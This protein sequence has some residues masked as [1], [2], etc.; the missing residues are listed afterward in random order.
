MKL[1]DKI[2]TWIGLGI[3]LICV[4]Y[5]IT[6]KNYIGA[7]GFF[8]AVSAETTVLRMIYKPYK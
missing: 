6:I 8:M 3:A 2:W 1:F 4:V 7:V 5:S